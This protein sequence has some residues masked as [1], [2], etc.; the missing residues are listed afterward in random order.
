[1]PDLISTDIK[2][3]AETPDAD[4]A[5]NFCYK[6]ETYIHCTSNTRFQIIHN[7]VVFGT[8]PPNFARF[9]APTPQIPIGKHP[10][11]GQTIAVQGQVRIEADTIEE[12]AEKLPS[13][14]KD[15][16]PK[17]KELARKQL[18]APKIVD[19]TAGPLPPDIRMNGQNFKFREG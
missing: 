16:I 12:A 18:M 6:P 5:L 19:P 11:T 8:A 9:E 10:M 13:V 4:E 17:I 7:R 2:N 14:F 15:H 1:M 3:P